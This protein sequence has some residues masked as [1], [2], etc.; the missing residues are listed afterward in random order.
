MGIRRKIIRKKK[1]NEA[2]EALAKVSGVKELEIAANIL[3][4]LAQRKKRKNKIENLEKMDKRGSQSN[5]EGK[6][7]RLRELENLMKKGMLTKGEFE[8]LKNDLH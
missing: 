3:K 8:K 5:S 2:S 6:T 4:E 7:E 1:K